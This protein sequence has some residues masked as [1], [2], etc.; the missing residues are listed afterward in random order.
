MAQSGLPVF[1]KLL[2]AN[3]KRVIG[4]A[5][6]ERGEGSTCQMLVEKLTR[7]AERSETCNGSEMIVILDELGGGTQDDAGFDLGCDML[8]TLRQRNVSTIFSSQILRLGNHARD[9]LD[10]ECFWL[11][12]D[13][14]LHSGIEGGGIDHLREKTGFDQHIVQQ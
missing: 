5:F 1:A 8:R 11:D 7:I 12:H 10:A 14:S 3:A 13:H 2:R 6:I 9:Q 4:T